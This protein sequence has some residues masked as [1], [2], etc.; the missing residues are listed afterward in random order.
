VHP[1]P[2]GDLHAQPRSRARVV[3]EAVTLA[4]G[5]AAAQLG[6]DLIAVVT[7]SGRTAMAVSKQRN[8][9][10]ILALSDNPATARR[11]TLYWGVS[12]LETDIVANTPQKLVSFVVDWGKRK[13]VLR[14]GSRVVVV[15]ST[16]WSDEAHD[17]M[18]V[19][20]VP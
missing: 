2:L 12:P 10:P 14:Q 17:L 5:T 8:Q 19:H 15:G 11:M 1:T 13:K 4:A 16:N 6:A 7:H 3:T 20:A 18:L 9:V